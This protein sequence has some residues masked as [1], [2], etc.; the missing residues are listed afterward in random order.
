MKSKDT[1]TMTFF[2]LA[3]PQ[4]LFEKMQADLLDLK[5]SGQD[6]YTAFNF[7]VTAEHLPDWLR[8]RDLV[9]SNAYLRV[10]SH[11]ANGAKHFKYDP[12]RHHAVAGTSKQR[13]FEKGYVSS[14]YA[15]EPLLIE[16]SANEAE[17][18]DTLVIDAVTLAQQ[19]LDFWRPHVLNWKP[20]TPE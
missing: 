12:S 2:E 18:L 1:Q 3:T 19:V 10:V 13:F 4:H 15:E 16:L 14:G 17:E 8:R 6:V 5:A 7:V 11:L 9:K 20:S